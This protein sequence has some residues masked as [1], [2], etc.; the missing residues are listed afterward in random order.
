V[1]QALAIR[2]VV[3]TMCES[4]LETGDHFGEFRLWVARLPLNE[5]IPFHYGFRELRYIPRRA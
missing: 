4:A 1:S 3:V 2:V 5:R